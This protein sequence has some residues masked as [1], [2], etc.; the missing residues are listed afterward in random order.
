M[1]VEEAATQQWNHASNNRPSIAGQL[2][3]PRLV[4]TVN[5]ELKGPFSQALRL[6]IGVRM[7]ISVYGADTAELGLLVPASPCWSSVE[8][9][10]G[11]CGVARGQNRPGRGSLCYCPAIAQ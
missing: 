6:A 10:L 7:K 2:L 3:Q 9:S 1:T 5:P 4:L 11:N 8:L